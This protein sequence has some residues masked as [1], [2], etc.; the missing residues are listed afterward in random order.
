MKAFLVHV[1]VENLVSFTMLC[2]NMGWELHDIENGNGGKVVLI[3]NTDS[4]IRLFKALNYS[5]YTIQ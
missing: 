4:M 1:S 3:S 2:K 5:I